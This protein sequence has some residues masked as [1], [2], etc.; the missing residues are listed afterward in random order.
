MPQMAAVVEWDRRRNGDLVYAECIEVDEN[1]KHERIKPS[2]A[3]DCCGR[4]KRKR[5]TGGAARERLV[6]HLKSIPHVAAL[7][8][9]SPFKV[10]AALKSRALIEGTYIEPQPKRKGRKR[11]MRP[12][13][14][15]MKT[16]N[17]RV[18][19]WQQRRDA[20]DAK[21]REWTKRQ[22][23]LRRDAA[24]QETQNDS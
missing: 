20:A 15:R 1:R 22:R 16:A 9:V 18:A 21:L 17:E 13:K 5:L 7:F 6:N 14:D 8:G 19:H 4:M 24:K 2:E 23:Q 3:R 11:D 12:L 10:A